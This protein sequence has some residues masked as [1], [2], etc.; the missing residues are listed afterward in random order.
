M[1]SFSKLM[2]VLCFLWTFGWSSQVSDSLQFHPGYILISTDTIG[3]PIYIGHILVGQSPL[4]GPIP[5]MEGL[6]Q[7][8]FIH[9]KIQKEYQ[10]LGFDDIV[11]QIYVVAGDTVNVFLYE[12]RHYEQ[13]A[14]IRKEKKL[15]NAIGLSLSGMALY[16]LWVLTF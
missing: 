8:S 5:V 3:V 11:R 2:A 1:S 12:G 4:K 9:P 16:L 14:F 13:I 6:H 15:S 10:E 7:V